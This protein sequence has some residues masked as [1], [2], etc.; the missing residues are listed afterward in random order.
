MI[1]Y[2]IKEQIADILPS[3]VLAILMGIIVYGLGL[4]LNVSPLL[5]LIIQLI[6]GASFTFIISELFKLKD[7][8]YIKQIVIE[9]YSELKQK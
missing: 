6:T 8:L 3:I 9:K 1:N 4:V 2:P 5:I 7:Y